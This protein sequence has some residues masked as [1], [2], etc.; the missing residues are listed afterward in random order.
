[1]YTVHIYEGMCINKY[2]IYT[3][4]V[5]NLVHYTPNNIIN[6]QKII[7]NFQQRGII[8]TLYHYITYNFETLSVYPKRSRTRYH[9]RRLL[10][11]YIPIIS[12]CIYI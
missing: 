7:I 4:L 9:M 2:R 10:T 1:M 11:G 12:V 5:Y 3:Y 8:L 6:N